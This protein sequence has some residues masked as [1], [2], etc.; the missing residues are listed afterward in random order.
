MTARSGT[1][2]LPREP[3]QVDPSISGLLDPIQKIITD[4]A[5]NFRSA[6]PLALW[7]IPGDHLHDGADATICGDQL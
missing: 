4:L 1:N 5:S 7:R 3:S 2:E 6:C